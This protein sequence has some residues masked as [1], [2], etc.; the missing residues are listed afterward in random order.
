MIVSAFLEP[1]ISSSRHGGWPSGNTQ[2]TLGEQMNARK[3]HCERKK[4]KIWSQNSLFCK[5]KHD[6]K[7]W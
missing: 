4:N 2:K 1:C 3:T 6:D 5:G 7:N